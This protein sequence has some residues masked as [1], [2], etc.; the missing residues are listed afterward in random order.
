MQSSTAE[1]EGEVDDGMFAAGLARAN[2]SEERRALIERRQERLQQRQAELAE[3]RAEV[4]DDDGPRLRDRALAA[5]VA[6][7]AARLERSANGTERAARAAGMDTETLAEIR[8]NASELRGSEVAALARNPTG[9]PAAGER[10]PPLG[11]PGDGGPGDGPG[12]G[13]PMANVT[14]ASTGAGV[15]GPRTAPGQGSRGAG[16][17]SP[18]DAG[19]IDS[20][21]GEY[22]DGDGDEGAGHDGDDGDDGDVEG[23]DPGN[24][25]G[26]APDRNDD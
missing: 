9:P 17:G 7:G 13:A 20:D 23:D 3:R 11:V 19:A 26:Q 1:A 22:T 16:N 24:A 21:D 18:D 8:S 15:S 25:D 10:G 4:T 2:S 5:Q 12:G 14:N 6:V